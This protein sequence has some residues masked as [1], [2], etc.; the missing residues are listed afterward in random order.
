MVLASFQIEDILEK[1]QFF[2]ETFLLAD[3]NIEVVLEMS[4]LAFN[5]ADIKL[6]PKK[7]T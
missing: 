4:F 1:A 7:L 3:L 5:N 6:A 2:W